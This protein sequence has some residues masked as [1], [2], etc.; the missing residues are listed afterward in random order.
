MRFT[1]LQL[2][3]IFPAWVIAYLVSPYAKLGD[4]RIPL[5]RVTTHEIDS[6]R[7]RAVELAFA[8]PTFQFADYLKIEPFSL[9]PTDVWGQDYQFVQFDQSETRDTQSTFHIFSYGNDGISNSNGNDP[10]DIN[11]WSNNSQAFYDISTAH[12]ATP[13]LVFR[14]LLITPIA[15]IALLW[16]TNW[17]RPQKAIAE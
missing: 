8:N 4:G 9:Y 13:S 15:Y 6:M 17:L 11:S 3:L 5:H 12:A 7:K 1:L 14:S 2:L 10:D 16:V